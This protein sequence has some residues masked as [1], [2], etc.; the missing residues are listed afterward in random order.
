MR[1]RFAVTTL[2][3]LL[4]VSVV[5]TASAQRRRGL[6]DVTRSGDRGGFWIGIGVGAG[7]E[8]S[9]LDGESRYTDGLTKPTFSIRGGGT[10][11][12]NLRLGGELFGWTDRHYDSQAA[13]NVTSY[14]GG[15]LLT[16]QFYPSR[17]S[18]FFV[19]GG[20]GVTRSGE[21]LAGPG[22]DLHEDGFGYSVGAGYEIKLSPAV[23][24][25]PT[26]DWYQHRSQIRDQQGVILPTFHD[27]LINIG[28]SLTFQSGR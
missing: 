3:L 22:G 10:V 9:K 15:L 27:R 12:P 21:D 19:K 23:F 7:T 18:G 16:G 14:F 13:D 11:N 6:V 1:Y 20:L 24:I 4:A 2:S 5:D 8:S 17:R 28:V 25:T 26:I